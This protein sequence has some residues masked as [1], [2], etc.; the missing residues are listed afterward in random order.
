MASRSSKSRVLERHEDAIDTIQAKSD[1][2]A[3]VGGSPTSSEAGAS[4]ATFDPVINEPIT[5]V[6]KF[7]SEDVKNAVRTAKECFETTWEGFTKADRSRLLH[8]W[9]GVLED[10]LEELALLECIDTGKPKSH[11]RGEVEGAIQ[12]LEY[13]ASICRSQDARQ[14]DARDDLHL[15]TRH[16]PYG[17][18]GQIIPWNF[19]LWALAWKL[20]PAIA[21]GN[22]T[23]LKPASDSPL[24]AIR[25]A[26]LS[27]GIF[28]DGV[29]NV[30]T[31]EGSTVGSA[32][33]ANDDIR[34]LSFTGSTE[35]GSQVMKSA[36]E[37]IVPVTLELGGKSPFIVFPDADLDKVVDAV[38]DGVF[39]STGEICDALSRAIVHEDIVDQFTD[40]LVE[41]AESYV[42][43][44]PL[45][46]ETTMGPLTNREQFETVKEYIEIGRQ[47]SATLLTGGHV[48]EDKALEDGWYIEPAVFSDVSNDMRIAQEE[49]FGP[50]QTVQSFET[51]EEAIELANDTT[52]GLVRLTPRRGHTI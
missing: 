14:I 13:Y 19:P 2:D 1:F 6:P 15:Y 17:V 51:Y 43:G 10:N 50:V 11:A 16:E 46:E 42:L 38:A 8:E 33:T 4:I 26:E 27:A 36:A 3:W 44:D 28:P 31:G 23:V 12:T 49:I 24:T 34:K 5:T 48:P 18:V 20:G 9:V 45:D 47:E 41:K 39:Y 22:C 52:F 37:N 25:A 32:M 35:V 29:I 7:E 21:A 40:R 30:I